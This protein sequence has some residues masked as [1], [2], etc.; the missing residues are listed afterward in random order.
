M[1]LLEGGNVFK[2]AKGKPLTQRI[3]NADVP[4]T[5]KWL[6]KL[7][8]LDLTGK[9]KDK[10]G[11]PA[12]WL[13]STGRRDTS[14]DLDIALDANIVSKEQLNTFLTQWATKNNLDPAQ[15]VKKAGELHFRTPI[16]GDPKQGFVQT[17][18]NFYPD[19]KALTWGTF[20]MSGSS[21]NY[22][23]M[24]R[25]VL[26]SSLVKAKQQG[27]KIG[28][29]GIVSRTTNKLIPNGQDPDLAAQK[30]LG[31]GK[32]RN[33]LATV[34]TIYDNLAGDPQRDAKLA[35]FR[36]YLAREGLAEPTLKE[37]NEV[38]FMAR[39]RDRIVNKGMYTLIE[40]AAPA[41]SGGHAKG[42]EH[43]EDLVFRKGSRGI[44]EALAIAEHAV[45]DTKSTVSV[46][47]DGIPAIV[48]G[49]DPDGAFVLTDV[50]GF[51]ARGYEGLARSPRQISDIMVKRDT[52]AAA[53]GNKANR[54]ET[55]LPI[56][57]TLWPLLSAA[58][59]EKFRGYV[60]GDLLYMTRP[61]LEAGAFV[62]K[63][64]TVE[65]RIPAASD[66]GQQIAASD[67]G[68]A[69]HTRYAEPGAPK[70]PVGNIKFNPVPGL[71]LLPPVLPKE[72]I[73]A[74]N[75][76]IKSIKA[77]NRQHGADI[78]QLFNP[79]DL[80]TQQITDLPSLC[81][82]Y[83]NSQVK[84]PNV[85]GFDINALLPGFGEYL[86]T[87][88]TPKK[89]N[90]IVEYLQ[91]PRSNT[92]ALAAAFTAF[93]QLHALKEDILNKLDLQHPG[94]EGWVMATPAGY[95]K[96]VNRFGFS[97]ANA[98]RNNPPPA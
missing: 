85:S 3:N 68:V 20:Y 26:L 15:F 77:L 56:Y 54:V 97:R 58:T 19:P 46:K 47:W 16:N 92:D 10:N 61:P 76:L 84:N 64:N 13:G 31:P 73:A 5:I 12:R 78:D 27:L 35:D 67:V 55:L 1:N 72:N 70:E 95:A 14:G 36:E 23:G 80:R 89:F 32:T 39:L 82:D 66:V 93:I 45:Q 87:K 24:A 34:E 40:A 38:N 11:V 53:K 9:E 71:L 88:V 98:A 59:P 50:A 86:Q 22:K 18:F 25:N 42:I 29:N 79:A 28:G 62:F 51:T 74:N 37:E 44:A 81:I 69:I 7:T 17:D 2:D 90:N 96:A 75:S 21:A 30:V 41:V 49:R 65:Y 6:E 91:S 60:Q 33:D 94:Q 52:D 43:L 57:T 4:G 8:K 83:I 63:P 48:W